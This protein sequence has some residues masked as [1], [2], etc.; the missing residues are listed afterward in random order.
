MNASLAGNVLTSLRQPAQTVFIADASTMQITGSDN[1]AMTRHHGGC[2]AAFVDGHAQSFM[3]DANPVIWGDGEV[4]TLFSLG[5]YAT[6]LNC[7]SDNS[8]EGTSAVVDEG[9]CVL[10]CN[11][12]S[13]VVSPFATI[14]GGPYSPQAGALKT[15]M[16][17]TIPPLQDRAFILNCRTSL[18]LSSI[19][20][21]SDPA[22][23][24]ARYKTD[25]TYQFGG[26]QNPVTITV[27][28]PD[29][30]LEKSPGESNSYTAAP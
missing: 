3:A 19:A 16:K 20:D 23:A 25:T 5:A 9:A 6:V 12:T 11:K 18:P 24:L 28:K 27:R 30:F 21:S 13:T 1:V 7:N 17:V 10:L 8:V 29:S 2:I 26:P 4:G 14:F 15:T 22:A